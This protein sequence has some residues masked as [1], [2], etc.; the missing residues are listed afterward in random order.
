MYHCC[1]RELSSDIYFMG[2]RQ[3]KHSHVC[4][5]LVKWTDNVNCLWDSIRL[6]VQTALC[7]SW[8]RVLAMTY[9]TSSLQLFISGQGPSLVFADSLGLF[10]SQLV[11]PFARFPVVNSSCLFCQRE[12]KQNNRGAANSVQSH[13]WEHL[14]ESLAGLLWWHLC[15]NQCYWYPSSLTLLLRIW[16]DLGELQKHIQGATVKLVTMFLVR[17]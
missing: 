12:R 13:D 14:K 6:I 5:H 17:E 9:L 16:F 2:E 8:E 7:D 3:D 1:I 15:T 11:S 4:L 10:I